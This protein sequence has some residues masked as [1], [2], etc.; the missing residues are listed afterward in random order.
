[1][2]LKLK[3]L[4]NTNGKGN[5]P[6]KSEVKEDQPMVKSESPVEYGSKPVKEARKE[7]AH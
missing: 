1:M 5:S 3:L 4:K 6:Q 2:K 7:K